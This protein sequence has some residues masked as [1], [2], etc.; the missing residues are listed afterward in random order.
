MDLPRDLELPIAS[1]CDLDTR[2]R[3]GIVHKLQVPDGLR[4]AIER[5]QGYYRCYRHADAVKLKYLARV[6]IPIGEQNHTLRRWITITR[7]V[8]VPV[9]P[10]W[11]LFSRPSATQLSEEVYTRDG[12]WD[13][14]LCLMRVATLRYT[15]RPHWANRKKWV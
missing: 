12:S 5:S 4:C 11:A 1:C 6:H 15:W 10:R 7:V 9:I 13:D 3:C 8:T 2:V 14:C